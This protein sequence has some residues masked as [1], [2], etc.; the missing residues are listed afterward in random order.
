MSLLVQE[1]LSETREP[2]STH[3]LGHM[4]RPESQLGGAA[5]D[6]DDLFLQPV[7]PALLDLLPVL[8]LDR[9]DLAVEEVPK[10]RSEIEELVGNPEER[11]A[12]KPV[13]CRPRLSST[14]SRR[15]WKRPTFS[16]V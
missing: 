10:G 14:L 9:P 6:A 1:D 7:Q 12:S 16:T 11:S 5:P 8:L 13:S 4:E 3:L 15:I 2:S